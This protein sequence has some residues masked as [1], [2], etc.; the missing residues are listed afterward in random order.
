MEEQVLIEAV[1]ECAN[2]RSAIFHTLIDRLFRNPTAPHIDRT[3]D[4]TLHK[5]HP[6]RDA[7]LQMRTQL[8]R[9]FSAIFGVHGAI[10]LPAT[11]LVPRHDTLHAP[12]ASLLLDESGA[13]VALPL[14]LTLPFARLVLR[15][16]VRRVTRF[17]F[18]HVYRRAQQS[19]VGAS[20]PKQL[21][22]W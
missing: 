15:R 3:Y 20:A 7:A 22:E 12:S 16:R 11:L 4:A 21:F 19:S 1:R 18:E 9:T 17:A 13:V 5:Q 2:P 10:E 6:L 14:D 8:V